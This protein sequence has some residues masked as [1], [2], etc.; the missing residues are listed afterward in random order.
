[1]VMGTVR[2]HRV[3]VQNTLRPSGLYFAKGVGAGEVERLSGPRSEDLHRIDDDCKLLPPTPKRTIEGTSSTSD[4]PGSDA[5]R[6]KALSPLPQQLQRGGYNLRAPLPCRVPLHR[7]PVGGGA[8]E[9][10]G[11]GY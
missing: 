4:S 3:M 11:G 10:A 7:W 2:G 9:G 8:D 1:M 6:P 5:K